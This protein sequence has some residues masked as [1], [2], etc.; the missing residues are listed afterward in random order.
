MSNKRAT[1]S[2]WSAPADPVT[3]YRRAGGRRRYNARR[4]LAALARRAK[5]CKLLVS[6][7]AA[8]VM[9]E[10][11]P[12]NVASIDRALK[13]ICNRG[14]QARI[15]RQLGVSRSTVCR[16]ITWVYREL[17]IWPTPPD[18]MDYVRERLAALW[19]PDDVQE[20]NRAIKV[21]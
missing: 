17:G 10:I 6:E 2:H 19:S 4:R 15:A 18:P 9:P 8:I 11:K 1:N 5:L 21:S 14:M 20:S 12:D 16:D 7:H 13:A 3:V